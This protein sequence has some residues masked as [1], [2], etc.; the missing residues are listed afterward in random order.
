M[1]VNDLRLK[2]DQN[3]GVRHCLIDLTKFQV[4]ISFLVATAHNIVFMQKS[5]SV[6]PPL[7]AHPDPTLICDV[8]L[9]RTFAKY[10][11][12]KASCYRGE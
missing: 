6:P 10:L 4:S 5:V 3:L 12:M 2:W 8:D 7:Y 9:C 1:E 11:L